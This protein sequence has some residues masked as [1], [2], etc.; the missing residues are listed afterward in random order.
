[1]KYVNEFRDKE[2]VEKALNLLKKEIQPD[3]T[4]RLLEF[5]GGHTHAIYRYGLP[6]ILP[7]QI[8]LIHGPGCPVCVLPM[9]KIDEAIQLAQ[10]DNV[11]LCTYG[12]MMR[13][14]GGNR[15]SLIKA[16]AEGADVH[17]VTSPLDAV[18]LAQENPDKEVVFFAI[19]FATTTPATAHVLVKAKELKLKNF[20][21]FCNHVLAMPP[22]KALLDSPKDEYELDGIIGPGHVAAVCGLSAFEMATEE[23]HKPVVV[24]G[25]EPLDLMTAILMLVRQVNDGRAEVENEYTRAIQ[26]EG[27]LKYQ[28]LESKVFTVRDKFEWRGLGE[29]DMSALRI[30]DDYAQF[31]AE[32]RFKIIPSTS[33]DNPACECP[34]I[35]RGEK[36]PQDCKLFGKVCNPENPIGACMVS[37]EGGCAAAYSYGRQRMVGA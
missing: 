29:I 31:D 15:M 27:N 5:C 23:Y 36:E 34:A 25:F 10:M 30:H 20:S 7:R 13:V 11:I 19:G 2:T 17:M 35:L 24:T 26:P 32:K 28:A 1:M 21:V 37:S 4:Y 12:D 22:L 6:D 9:A 8:K 18:K 14:P 16:K 33:T 3:R